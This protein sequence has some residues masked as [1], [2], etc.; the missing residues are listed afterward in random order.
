MTLHII[1]GGNEYSPHTTT[2]DVETPQAEPVDPKY[3]GS[4]S[5]KRDMMAMGRPQTLL[6]RC[7][8]R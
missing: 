5:D 6:V 1:L 2:V 4:A 3:M 8:Q 7:P